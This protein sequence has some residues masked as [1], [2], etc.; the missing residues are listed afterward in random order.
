MS[1]LFPKLSKESAS[2]SKSSSPTNFKEDLLV[3]DN[4]GSMICIKLIS[5]TFSFVQKAF[6]VGLSMGLA[7]NVHVCF[8]SSQVIIVRAYQA[9]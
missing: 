1:P 2:Q 4:R 7:V 5:A 8:F 6:L 9:V 3:S